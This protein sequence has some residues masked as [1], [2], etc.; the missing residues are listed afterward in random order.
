MALTSD[1]VIRLK[2]ECGYNIVSVGAEAYALES[3]VALFDRAIQP[4][5]ID[6]ATTSTSVVVAAAGGGVATLL[7]ASNP[8]ATSNVTQPLAFTQG[9]NIVLD[10]GPSTETSVIL[11]IAALTIT[12]TLALAHGASSYPVRVRGAEQ[13]I[14]DFIARLDVISVE[15]TARA[16]L[17]A[18]IA[19]VD[20]IELSASTRGR[21]T[22]RNKFDDL[23]TQ[24]TRTRRDIADALGVP[25][26]PDVRASR[27]AYSTEAY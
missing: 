2:A 23:I 22:T 16:P 27:G 6:L 10:V 12:C 9:S 5:L 17:T 11:T 4:Y 25:Y 3:Y 7:L 21:Q 15:L 20:E 1:E 14:R 8:V 19:K 26:M 13:Y 24:R 18:G